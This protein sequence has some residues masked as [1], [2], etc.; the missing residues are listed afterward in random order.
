MV[1]VYLEEK[2]GRRL[3]QITQVVTTFGRDEDNDYVVD[4]NQY[5]RG[6][7]RHHGAFLRFDLGAIFDSEIEND[8]GIKTE[9]IK[10][11]TTSKLIPGDTVKLEYIFGVVDRKSRNGV[12]VNGK[13]VN[14]S[15]LVDGDIVA[16]ASYGTS[17]GEPWEWKVRIV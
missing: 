4:S 1:E 6:V 15:Y 13:R 2:F 8:K 5:S 12:W 16:C 11:D 7:S 10:K 14:E 9:T 17:K 3:I